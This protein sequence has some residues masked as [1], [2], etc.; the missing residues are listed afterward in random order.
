[1]K[2]TTLYLISILAALL[3]LAPLAAQEATRSL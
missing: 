2:K 3:M 1:M